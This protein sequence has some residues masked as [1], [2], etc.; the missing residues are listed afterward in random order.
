MFGG[1]RIA[2]AVEP[3]GQIISTTSPFVD[4]DRVTLLD[5]DFDQMLQDDAAFARF[6]NLHGSAEQ[7]KA[8]L[9]DIPG[10][11]V[12]LDKEITIEF[13]PGKAF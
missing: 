4:G 5:L 1:M 10:L 9:K 13:R 6:Q 8:A 3:V 2:I 12:C 7:M 11:K